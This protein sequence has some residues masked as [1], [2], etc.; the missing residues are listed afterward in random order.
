M[1]NFYFSELSRI[2]ETLGTSSGKGSVSMHPEIGKKSPRSRAIA[3]AIFTSTLVD[4]LVSK[5]KSD[6]LYEIFT[7]VEIPSLV[8]LSHMEL[9]GFG[10]CQDECERQRKVLLARLEELEEKVIRQ[11]FHRYSKLAGLSFTY[12]I[13]SK[14]RLTERVKIAFKI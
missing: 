6:G 11:K 8:I 12:H 10:F 2:L 4:P 9:N 14:I 5:L 3:E 13:L 7:N 1:K